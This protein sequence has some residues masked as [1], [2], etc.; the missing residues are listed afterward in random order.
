MPGYVIDVIFPG[1]TPDY[2]EKPG[3]S[4]KRR[5]LKAST[6]WPP[7]FRRFRSLGVGIFFNQEYDSFSLKKSYEMFHLVYKSYIKVISRNLWYMSYKY[8]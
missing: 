6:T 3:K 8:L 1:I 5:F 7:I 2:P 4:W